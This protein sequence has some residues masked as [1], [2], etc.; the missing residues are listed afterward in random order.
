MALRMEVVTW[1]AFCYAMLMARFFNT[2]G[3]CRPELNY[4]LPPLR[5]VPTVRGL[6]EQQKYFVLHAPR[7]AGKTTAL[8]RGSISWLSSPTR[9]AVPVG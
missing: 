8:P 7:Q 2:S 4:M 5:R 9:T 1:A 6:I 3:P